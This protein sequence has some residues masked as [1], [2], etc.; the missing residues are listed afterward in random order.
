MR[1]PPVAWYAARVSRF[2]SRCSHSESS[3][4]HQR[5]A[6]RLPR[7][8]VGDGLREPC[9]WTRDRLQRRGARPPAATHRRHL[10]N[11]NGVGREQVGK[12]WVG[13]RLCVVVGSHG[14]DN[15]HAV[16]GSGTAS[17]FTYSSRPIGDSV[18]KSSSNWSTTRTV[19]TP[20]RHDQEVVGWRR[21]HRATARCRA[22]CRHEGATRPARTSDDLP[23]PDAPTTARSAR[24]PTWP[25]AVRRGGPA[26]RSTGRHQRRRTSAPCRG[27]R[28]PVAQRVRAPTAPAVCVAGLGCL[29]N[30]LL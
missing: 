24:P 16:A 22:A 4:G 7:N 18:V 10:T 8:V 2:P 5:Q 27:T 28:R 14:D 15:S 3:G 13:R 26:P 12:A 21:Q 1:T 23:L 6:A 30:P 17:Q 11:E 29:G 9:L 20:L 19:R 25:R